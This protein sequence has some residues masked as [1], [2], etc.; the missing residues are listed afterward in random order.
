MVVERVEPERD[1]YPGTANF[2]G[3]G[4]WEQHRAAPARRPAM[5]EI[6]NTRRPRKMAREA[7]APGTAAAETSNAEFGASASAAV[8]KPPS[9]A[10]RV[11]DLLRR[12]EGVTL[13]QLVEATGWLPHTTRAALT[14]LRKKGHAIIK[15]KADGLTRYTIAAAA[16][17]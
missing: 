16:S 15:D 7:S 17:E 14:G 8:P 13:A 12:P 11:L 1:G 4:Q 3:F 10:S 6:T 9:K 2:P 5:S